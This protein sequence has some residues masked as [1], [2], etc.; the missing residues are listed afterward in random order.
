M[1]GYTQEDIRN[2][3][4]GSERANQMK[5]EIDFIFRLIVGCTREEVEGVFLISNGL[6]KN[7]VIFRVPMGEINNYLYVLIF[8]KRKR[9]MSIDLTSWNNEEGYESGKKV[10]FGL[11]HGVSNLSLDIVKHVHGKLPLIL[12]RAVERFSYLADKIHRLTEYAEY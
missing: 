3:I 9:D 11:E 10:F 7:E 12:E 5:R 2:L 6:A 1:S 8:S 4:A